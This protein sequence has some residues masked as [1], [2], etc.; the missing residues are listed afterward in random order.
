MYLG[1]EKWNIVE[2]IFRWGKTYSH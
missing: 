1:K 2:T